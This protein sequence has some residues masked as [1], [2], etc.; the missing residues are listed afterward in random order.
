MFTEYRPTLRL[1]SRLR[2]EQGAPSLN[3]TTALARRTRTDTIIPSAER[4]MLHEAGLSCTSSNH[5]H[6]WNGDSPSEP[7]GL[8]VNQPR[9]LQCVAV[10][11]E[12]LGGEHGVS[13]HL[14]A[15]Q[16]QVTVPQHP[17]CGGPLWADAESDMLTLPTRK[18]KETVASFLPYLG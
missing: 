7:P 17:V 9:V 15:R 11:R 16:A 10:S 1:N 12:A 14:E 3:N 18:T 5:T 8:H 6:L 13:P 4:V 2:T